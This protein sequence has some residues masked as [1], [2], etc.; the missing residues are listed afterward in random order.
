M[1]TCVIGKMA[2]YLQS[3][4]ILFYSKIKKIM[5]VILFI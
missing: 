1:G 4:G 3:F 5:S 2:A